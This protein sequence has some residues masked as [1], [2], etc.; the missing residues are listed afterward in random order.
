MPPI[1]HLPPAERE[2]LRREHGWP[3]DFRYD[4]G[5]AAQGAKKING[6]KQRPEGAGDAIGIVLSMEFDE[7][8][9]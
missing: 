9:F 3:L 1:P 2:L 5:N 8:D 7:A 6:R 4:R